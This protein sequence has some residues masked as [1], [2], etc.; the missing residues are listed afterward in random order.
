MSPVILRTIFFARILL[1]LPFMTVAG[2]VP[3]LMETWQIGAAKVSSI[4]SGFYFAYAISLLSFSWLAGRIGA[5]RAVILSACATAVS[6]AAFA[7]SARDYTSSL[8]FYSLIGLCQGGVYTPLIMLFREN[9]PPERLGSAI[10]ALIASTSVGYAASIGITGFALGFSGWQTAFIL[11]G[12]API[13]GTLILLAAIGGLENVVH[14]RAANTRLWRQ[15]RENRSARRLL[16]GYT[17]HNWELIGIWSWAPAFIA[18]SFALSGQDTVTATQSSAYFVTTLHLVGAVAAYSM[19]KLSDTIGRRTVLIWAA[20]IATAFSFGIGWLVVFTPY[21]IAGL[22]ILHSFFALGD[23]PVLSTTM[24]ERV[25]PGALGAM[26]ALRSVAGFTTGAISPVVFG[27]V[28]DTL[29]AANAGESVIWGAAFATL[30]LGGLL[31][32][33]FAVR[34]PKRA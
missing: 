28:V 29:R 33:C 3:V 23:S 26:L 16:L 12:T 10:G 17:C 34:L 1:F 32:V 4:V 30:G 18:A 24:A 13:A 15:L 27:F 19:G 7:A 2:C 6:C 11:T 14:P 31:A 20:V 25:E 22:I 9:T 21:L 8:I 5:K